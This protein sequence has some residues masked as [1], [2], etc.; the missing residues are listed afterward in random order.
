MR[1]ASWH[2]FKLVFQLCNYG[3]ILLNKTRLNAESSS[4]A[5]TNTNHSLSREQETCHLPTNFPMKTS[6][7][8][9]FLRWGGQLNSLSMVSISSS[10]EPS[11]S[12]TGVVTEGPW[13][14]G[15]VEKHVRKHVT[16]LIICSFGSQSCFRNSTIT[17]ACPPHV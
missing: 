11:Y 15:N 7:K 3:F 8:N 2:I 12:M 6:E 10:S 16:R 9:S 13:Q 1:R 14:L 5:G 17:D 4:D